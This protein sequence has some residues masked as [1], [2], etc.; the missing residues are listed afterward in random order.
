MLTVIY[1]PKILSQFFLAGVLILPVFICTNCQNHSA[2]SSRTE[3]IIQHKDECQDACQIYA[4]VLS[5][6]LT[7][8]NGKLILRK[9][10][11]G[12]TSDSFLPIKGYEHLQGELGEAHA[13]L[14]ARYKSG[15]FPSID[16][17]ADLPTSERWVSVSSFEINK[18]FERGDADGGY[19]ELRKVFPDF[20]S[21]VSL[22]EVIFNNSADEALVFYIQSSSLRTGGGEWLLFTKSNGNWKMSRRIQM[23]SA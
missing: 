12:K 1:Q 17:S 9:E 3:H 11:A 19:G 5:D 21:L 4:A 2:A 20:C 15:K 14:L 7:N 18:I 22:S 13:D 8:C 16:L 10:S 23:F 6:R